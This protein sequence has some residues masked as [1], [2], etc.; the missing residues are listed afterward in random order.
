MKIQIS[1]NNIVFNGELYDNET[2]IRIADLIPFSIKLSRWGDEFYGTV[3]LN[4]SEAD[5]STDLMKVGELAYWPPGDAFCL[6]FG[7]TPAS[8]GNEP[9]M[10]SAGNPFGIVE[11]DFS[12]LGKSGDSVTIQI[13]KL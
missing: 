9:R 1:V 11:G 3:G 7:P 10:A 8:M 13:D 12:A 2:A 6:F 4:L 5:D